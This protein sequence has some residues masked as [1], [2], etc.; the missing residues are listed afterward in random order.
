[1][2]GI[3][4]ATCECSDGS[5]DQY[6]R[7]ITAE[8]ATMCGGCEGGFVFFFLFLLFF[9]LLELIDDRGR[10]RVWSLVGGQ[11]SSQRKVLMPLDKVHKQY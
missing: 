2:V 1:M 11:E 7:R 4:L 6:E 9:K 10:I 8:V 3:W 5:G